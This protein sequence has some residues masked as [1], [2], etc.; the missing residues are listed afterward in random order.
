MKLAR[1]LTASLLMGVA[2]I[3]SPLVSGAAEASAAETVRLERDVSKYNLSDSGLALKGYDPVAYF[4]EGGGKPKKGKKSRTFTHEGVTYRFASSA[5]LETFKA[6]PTKYEPAYGGWCAYAMS[7]E[8]YTDI[9]PKNFKIEDGRLMV[10]YK[11]LLGDT[12]KSWNKEGPA[13]LEPLA[14]AYW[15]KESGEAPPA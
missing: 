9:D 8:K 14:D 15:E 5:N 3:G 6:N 10:F 13:T 1:T 4:P 7:K 11:G 12:L 2:L